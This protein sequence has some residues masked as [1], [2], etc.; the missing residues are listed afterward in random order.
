MGPCPGTSAQK[1]S[2]RCASSDWRPFS[3]SESWTKMWSIGPT[4]RRGRRLPSSSSRCGSDANRPAA[5]SPRLAAAD[6]PHDF[7]HVTVG[8]GAARVA[9]AL[10]DLAVYLDRDG[11]RIDA[12]LTDVI[13]QRG[14]PR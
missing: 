2:S 11:A 7:D 13:E 1:P 12:Q 8:Q 9:V 10:E 6:H 4:G 3:P 5:W 14:G